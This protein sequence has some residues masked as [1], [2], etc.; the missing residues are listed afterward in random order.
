MNDPFGIA[1]QNV[2]ALQAH[3][4]KQLEGRDAGG[5]G[6]VADQRRFRDVTVGQV[7]RVE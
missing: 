7:H 3:G 4:D 2:L 5:A 6:T 1:Q